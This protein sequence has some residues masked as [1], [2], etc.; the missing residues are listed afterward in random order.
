MENA[1]NIYSLWLGCFRFVNMSKM[2]Y[3]LKSVGR[4]P[5]IEAIVL[6]DIETCGSLVKCFGQLFSGNYGYLSR[7]GCMGRLWRHANLPLYIS[8]FPLYNLAKYM[9][10]GRERY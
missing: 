5:C 9:H 2:E 10:I 1:P 7:F 8:F 4:H 6:R 3:L